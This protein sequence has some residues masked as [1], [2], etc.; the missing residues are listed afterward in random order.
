MLSHIIP[1][2]LAYPEDD[3]SVSPL[4]SHSS[5]A[6]SDLEAKKLSL[7]LLRGSSVSPLSTSSSGSSFPLPAS[8]S[9]ASTPLSSSGSD[10]YSSSPASKQA[11]S[12]F[13]PFVFAMDS[14]YPHSYSTT[15]VLSSSSSISDTEFEQL[16]AAIG[17]E[18]FMASLQ[19]LP[20]LPALPTASQSPTLS[21]S[22]FL[23]NT[24]TPISVWQSSEN[25]W[26]KVFSVPS[27]T[28]SVFSDAHTPAADVPGTSLFFNPAAESFDSDFSLDF[29]STYI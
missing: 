9:S 6:S 28:D 24:P 7:L 10:S 4:S 11:P 27:P 8:S 29:T 15:S 13:Q 2:R 12:A 18:E 16:L 3:W 19:E 20:T 26:T 21:P 22:L 17:S 14:M 1:G 25:E 5:D 23:D